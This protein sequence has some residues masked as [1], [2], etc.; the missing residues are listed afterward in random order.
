[1][2]FKGENAGIQ[3]A[4]LKGVSRQLQ[5]WTASLGMSGR[6]WE[7][8]KDEIAT[9]GKCNIEAGAGKKVFGRR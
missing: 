4:S 8:G 5:R 3:N 2:P 1:M 9:Y 6:K 7:G